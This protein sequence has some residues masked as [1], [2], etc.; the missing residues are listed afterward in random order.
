MYPDLQDMFDTAREKGV[1]PLITESYISPE[2]ADG[3]NSCELEHATGL[4]IDIVS[5]DGDDAFDSMMEWFSENAAQYGFII[6]YPED[7]YSITGVKDAKGHLRYVGP[8]NAAAMKESGQCLEEFLE[9][10]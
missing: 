4:A 10:K 2:D 3:E 7:K 8:E 1:N 6:R 9:A 5:K